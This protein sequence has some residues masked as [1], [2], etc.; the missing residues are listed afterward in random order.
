MKASPRD[1]TDNTIPL[2]IS[3]WS[4]STGFFFVST[5]GCS[6]FKPAIIPFFTAETFSATT[7]SSAVDFEENGPRVN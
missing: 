6:P 5:I 3:N 1:K 7:T 2:A 4:I